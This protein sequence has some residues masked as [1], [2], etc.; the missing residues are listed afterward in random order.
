M[1]S[2]DVAPVFKGLILIIAMAMVFVGYVCRRRKRTQNDQ[3]MVSN[4]INSVEKEKD[5]RMDNEEESIDSLYVNKHVNEKET[6]ACTGD[7]GNQVRPMIND[8]SKVPLDSL[9]GKEK[10]RLR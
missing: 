3:T 2:N 10:V 5:E 7:G 4:N 9:K 1:M 6:M 8:L